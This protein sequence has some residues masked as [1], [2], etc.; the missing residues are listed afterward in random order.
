M[1]PFDIDF[2]REFQAIYFA[3]GGWPRL[4]RCPLAVAA[5]AGPSL[6][7]QSEV[8]RHARPAS[9]KRYEDGLPICEMPFDAAY[10]CRPKAAEFGPLASASAPFGD[11]LRRNS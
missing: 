3:V 6:S 4:F 2:L 5:I 1:G 8:P 9:A 10:H 7:V 11:G